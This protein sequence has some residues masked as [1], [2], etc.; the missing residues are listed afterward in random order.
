MA[1]HPYFPVAI[2]LG[3]LSLY[4]LGFFEDNDERGLRFAEHERLA[5]YGPNGAAYAGSGS[6]WRRLESSLA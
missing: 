2:S 4:F 5:S 1:W 3:Q 6:L